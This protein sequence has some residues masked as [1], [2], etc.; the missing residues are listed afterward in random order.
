MFNKLKKRLII[1]YM[2]SAGLLMTAIIFVTLYMSY[3]QSVQADNDKFYTKAGQVIEYFLSKENY[4]VSELLEL[5]EKYGLYISIRGSEDRQNQHLRSELFEEMM[6]QSEAHSYKTASNI[7]ASPSFPDIVTKQYESTI[8]FSVK[9]SSNNRYYCLSIRTNDSANPVTVDMISEIDFS[10][11]FPVKR[12]FVFVALELFGAL[13]IFIISL[14]LIN[15]ALKPIKENY[16]KQADFIASA[17]HE[18][19]SPLAVIKANASAISSAYSSSA[20]S[21]SASCYIENINNECSRMTKLVDDMLLLASGSSESWSVQKKPEDSELLFMEAY[22]L[23]SPLC[24]ASSH[25]LTL[26]L[27]D[28]VLP[29]VLIDRARILQ[30]ISILIDNAI[31][32][33]PENSEI[34]LR[35]SSSHSFITIEVEDHGIGIP[36]KQKALVTERFFRTDKAHTDRNHY[37]LGLSIAAE[38]LKAHDSSIKIKDTVNGGTIV[39]FK[40]NCIS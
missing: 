3:R 1:I 23:F 38:I 31:S 30:V 26:S 21:S 15:R 11:I 6:A 10:M 27:P 37:G 12:L 5:E 4:P 29:A 7:I 34:M 32:Y 16:T 36:D 17:S 40:I 14:W 28:E 13:G 18:L 24:E 20:D 19:K 25:K 2:L 8:L 33:S 39:Y 35:V 22:E 9:D